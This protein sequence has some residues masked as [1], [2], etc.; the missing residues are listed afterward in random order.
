MTNLDHTLEKMRL[1]ESAHWQLLLE[2]SQSLDDFKDQVRAAYAK[3]NINLSDKAIEMFIEVYGLDAPT[4]PEAAERV[5]NIMKNPSRFI[6]NLKRISGD[7]SQQMAQKVAAKGNAANNPEVLQTL[8]QVLQQIE[9][10]TSKTSSVE[11]TISSDIYELVQKLGELIPDFQ[12]VT[13]IMRGIA[14]GTTTGKHPLYGNNLN[15]KAVTVL[16]TNQEGTVIVDSDFADKLLGQEGLDAL[17]KTIKDRGINYMLPVLSGITSQPHHAWVLIPSTKEVVDVD[18]SLLAPADFSSIMSSVIDKNPRA[19]KIIAQI[20][21][22]AER[23]AMTKTFAQASDIQNKLERAAQGTGHN[24]QKYRR[25]MGIDGMEKES[26]I[27][28][29]PIES[30]VQY[31][32]PVVKVFSYIASKNLGDLQITHKDV[33]LS[34]SIQNMVFSSPSLDVEF[35]AIPPSLARITRIIIKATDEETFKELQRYIQKIGLRL[36]P[37]MEGD[38]IIINTR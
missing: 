11:E 7:N 30:G 27:I 12:E 34:G 36:T 21:D 22:K 9:K 29:I 35:S 25:I 10:N 5:K 20:T 14:N 16:S 18:K 37:K 19:A 4:T 6:E 24:L 17:N 3:Q 32:S 28:R 13:K 2:I 38:K 26:N 23:E 15:G 8:T 31:N 33:L 1:M